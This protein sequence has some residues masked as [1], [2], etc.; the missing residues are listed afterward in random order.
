MSTRATSFLVTWSVTK[1][2]E[3]TGFRVQ[4]RVLGGEWRDRV[5]HSSSTRQLRIT[6]LRPNTT[7]E[8]RVVALQGQVPGVQSYIV[9]SRTAASGRQEYGHAHM[10]TH[11]RACTHTH[12]HTC[13]RMPTRHRCYII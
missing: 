5:S 12:T 9:E 13:T 4:Y 6:S 3:A 2:V 11:A 7:Y 10:H 8:V 1:E